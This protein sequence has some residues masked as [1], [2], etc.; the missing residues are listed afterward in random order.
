[1]LG[2]TR[3]E[4]SRLYAQLQSHTDKYGINGE[5]AA[6]IQEAQVLLPSDPAL[7]ASIL[8]EAWLHCK[9]ELEKIQHQAAVLPRLGQ[10]I[11]EGYRQEKLR[12]LDEDLAEMTS[13][14]E[15]LEA[16]QEVYR[17]HLRAASLALEAVSDAETTI[18]KLRMR[19]HR[20]GQELRVEVRDSIPQEVG[21]PLEESLRALRQAWQRGEGG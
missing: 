2:D 19:R 6:L 12:E 14:R 20:L 9:G 5:V 17:Q 8:S 3:S 7:A 21:L 18:R 11:D 1:M 10:M 15:R 16:H 4:I 13:A